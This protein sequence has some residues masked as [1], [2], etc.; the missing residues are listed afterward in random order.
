M[1]RGDSTRSGRPADLGQGIF[2]PIHN[3]NQ[4]SKKR[5]RPIFRRLSFSLSRLRPYR[6]R[7]GFLATGRLAF[8]F[9][10]GFALRAFAFGPLFETDFLDALVLRA[11]ALVAD[12]AGVRLALAA[13]FFFFLMTLAL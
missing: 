10:A 6:F 12:L 13:G 3:R 8:F 11:F 1:P 5:H 2:A 9:L 4:R 7:F